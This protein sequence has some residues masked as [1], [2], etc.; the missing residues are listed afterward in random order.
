L[1]VQRGGVVQE[2][3]HAWL[4]A[5]NGK[6]ALRAPLWLIPTSPDL[7]PSRQFAA[8]RL[9]PATRRYDGHNRSVQAT[10]HS[11]SRPAPRPRTCCEMPR[12]ITPRRLRVTLNARAR[13]P[14]LLVVNRQYC[15]LHA[16]VLSCSKH[17]TAYAGRKIHS[18]G[19]PGLPGRPD[20]CMVVS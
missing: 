5:T 15:K 11:P 13:H 7:I 16:P 17:R 14:S 4:Q 2:S 10:A 8:H 6:Q 9:A 1:S 18:M 12:L 20:G 19:S 3:Q